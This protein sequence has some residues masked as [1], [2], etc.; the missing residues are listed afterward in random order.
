MLPTAVLACGCSAVVQGRPAAGPREVDQAYFF[1]GGVPVYGQTVAAP[2]VAM[3]AYL[4]A[5]RRIDV[6]GIA[7]RDVLADVGEINSVGTLFAFNECD[8]DF[9]I[10]G[11]SGRR[12]ASVELLMSRNPGM[13]VSAGVGRMPVYQSSLGA[14]DD[15]VQLP[16]ERL[17]NAPA[18]QT[19]DRPFVKVGLTGRKDCALVQRIAADVAE[20]LPSAVLPPRDAVAAYPAPLA[21]RDPCEVLAVV[22]D[23]V[24]AWDVGHSQPYQCRLSLR[25]PG[26]AGAVQLSVRLM[27]RSVEAMAAG[28]QRQDQNGVEIYLNPVSCEGV[29][30]VGP[31]MQRRVFGRDNASELDVSIRPAVVVDAGKR[32]CDVAAD[33]TGRAARLY[34]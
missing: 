30:F 9:K 11:E 21:E 10:S 14:C 5:L 22:G 19:P 34:N 4:R 12:I 20:R 31:P 27:P 2:D 25:Q 8:V 15:L 33:V 32:D 26:R 18:P 6:C 23:R 17:P 3:L 16:L 29:S 7:A 13:L 1:A 24:D 28:W